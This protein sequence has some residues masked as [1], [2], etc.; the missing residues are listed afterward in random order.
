LKNQ[1]IWLNVQGNRIKNIDKQTFFW[2]MAKATSTFSE[3]EEGLRYKHAPSATMRSAPA[4]GGGLYL[5]A[6]YF[7]M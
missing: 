5:E 6:I 3:R 4:G 2:S 7:E 1:K